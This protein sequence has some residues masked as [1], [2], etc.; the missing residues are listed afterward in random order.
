MLLRPLGDRWKCFIGHDLD[1]ENRQLLVE[2]KMAAIIDHNLQV[3]ARQVFLHILQF[4]RVCQAG[5]VMPSAGADRDAVQFA[6][7]GLMW[8]ADAYL[9]P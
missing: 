5:P 9:R 6:A 3:D 2:E 8:R 4:H 7:G 1:E